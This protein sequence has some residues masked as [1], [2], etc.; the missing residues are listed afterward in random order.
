MFWDVSELTYD[1]ASQRC[2]TPHPGTVDLYCPKPAYGAVYDAL[3]A[4]IAQ[5][6]LPIL[7]KP[8]LAGAS[9][10]GSAGQYPPP[11]YVEDKPVSNPYPMPVKP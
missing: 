6:F 1:A 4:G 7:M 8:D 2:V 9:S 5:H 10:G 3:V 11:D